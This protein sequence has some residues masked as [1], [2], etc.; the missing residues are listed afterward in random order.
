MRLGATL[1]HLSDAPPH[2]VA[3]RARRL[4]GAGFRSLW[5]PEIIGR[6]RLV[7]DPF[8]ALAA[9]AAATDG[10]EL[11]TGTVQVP[12]HHPAELAHRMLSLRAVCG[13]RLS[14]GVSPGSTRG[15]YAALDRDHRTR[16]RVFDENVV[17]LRALLTAGG[18][19]H[20][21]LSDPPAGRPPLLLGS[22]GANVEKA[23]RHFEGWLGSG[24][25][26][27]PDEMVAALGR[28]RAAGGGRAVAY[29]VPVPAGGDLGRIGE[30]L[31]RYADAG[32]DDAVVVIGPGGPDPERV[33]AL[34]P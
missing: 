15:D 21:R 13:D 31:R 7:P 9:A 14:L 25:R 8:V 33:R 29:A 34:L 16:F 3:E 18:D 24:S 20:A 6:G 5:A 32:F 4:A 28:F 12:L 17:R 11:G 19:D 1:A 26:A 23:A 27:T 30:H 2:P 22:W 10:V